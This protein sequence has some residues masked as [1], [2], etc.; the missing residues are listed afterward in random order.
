MELRELTALNGVSGDEGAVRSYIMEH[1]SPHADEIRTDRMGNL[2]AFKKG[3]GASKN[4][5]LVAAHMDEVGLIVLGVKDDGLIVYD[6]VGGIDARVMVS[7]RVRVANAQV[8]GVI[9]CKAIHLQTQEERK[10]PLTHKQ[11]FIDIGAKDKAECEKYVKPG[12]Y[13]AFE[14]GYMAFGDGFI[15]DKALDDRVGCYNM[16]RLIRNTYPCDVTFAFTVQEEVGLR[17][18]TVAARQIAATSAIVLEGTTANDLGDVPDHFKVCRAG[19]GVAI[20]F[21]DNSSIAH[22]GLHKRL[23]CL[24]SQQDIPWQL[25]TY[26]SGGNDAGAL[27]RSAGALPVSTLSVPCRSIHSPANVCNL[28]DIDAQYRLAHAFLNQGGDID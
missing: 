9:G 28:R 8:P 1:A 5:V 12:D 10:N 14:S 27:Q 24:A 26:V 3:T 23:K 11:M 22:P 15:K 16:L 21:M 19:A 2:L 25:K 17:G 4:H 20:S 13:V 6:T 7:K 18:A